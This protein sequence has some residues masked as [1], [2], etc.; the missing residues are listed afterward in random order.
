MK[1]ISRT[2]LLMLVFISF[3]SCSELI[4]CIASTKPVLPSK[5]FP[6]G[7][8]GNPYNENF[9]AEVR[10]D[11]NDDYYYYYFDVNGHLPPGINYHCSGRRITFSG[12]P[13]TAG[14]YEFTVNLTIDY[15]EDY[16]NNGGLFNDSNRICFGDDSTSRKYT[17]TVQ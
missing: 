14:I 10:N 6:D 11:P 15:P 3:N 7:I 16:F 8:V 12:T 5:N 9:R 17:I 13:S 4:D 2:L 1:T